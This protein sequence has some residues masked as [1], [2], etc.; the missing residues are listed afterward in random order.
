MNAVPFDT[1]KMARRLEAAGFAAPQAAGAAE[2]LAEALTGADLA[3]KGDL[4]WLRSEIKA[5]NLAFQ[6][7]MKADNLAFQ[8]EIKGDNVSFRTEVRSEFALFRRD[9]ELMRRDMTIKLGGM[10]FVGVGVIL[11]ALRY[12]PPHL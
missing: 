12:L 7:E 6:T 5:D 11:A 8:T 2:A 4:V 3:T 1:L 9:M 10:I